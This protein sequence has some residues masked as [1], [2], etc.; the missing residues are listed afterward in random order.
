[1]AGKIMSLYAWIATDTE[2]A[3]RILELSMPPFHIPL[4]GA[5]RARVESYRE[6]ARRAAPGSRLHL[7][8]FSAG[9]IVDTIA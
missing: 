2:G 8:M 5:D 9:V 6:R 7:K 1:M 4:V 3:E